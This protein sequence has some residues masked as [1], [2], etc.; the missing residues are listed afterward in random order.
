MS[1]QAST[2]AAGAYSPPSCAASLS[3]MRRTPGLAVS[4]ISLAA[5]FTRSTSAPLLIHS[6]P[7]CQPSTDGGFSSVWPIKPVRSEVGMMPTSGRVTPPLRR[8]VPATSSAGHLTRAYCASL[9]KSELNR[10]RSILRIS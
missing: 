1:R 7:S 3:S 2:S 4:L 5:K 10:T 8:I 6:V 9:K